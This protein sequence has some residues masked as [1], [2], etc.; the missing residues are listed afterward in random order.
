MLKNGNY[1]TIYVVDVKNNFYVFLY[2]IFLGKY[3]Q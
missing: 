2:F 1:K 3:Q